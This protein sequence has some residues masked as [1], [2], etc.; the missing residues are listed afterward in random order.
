MEGATWLPLTVLVLLIVAVETVSLLSDAGHRLRRAISS[1]GGA[2]VIRALAVMEQ[3]GLRVLPTGFAGEGPDGARRRLLVYNLIFWALVTT[4]GAA[5]LLLNWPWWLAAV[6]VAGMLVLQT[7]DFRDALSLKNHEETGSQSRVSRRRLL[8]GLVRLLIAGGVLA[9]G[10]GV[11]PRMP[12]GEL[13]LRSGVAIGGIAILYAAVLIRRAAARYG[14]VVD[15]MARFGED[16]S[17]SDV[18]MLRSFQDDL[19]SMRGVDPLL[20]RLGLLV[21][22]RVRFEECIASVVAGQRRLIAIGQP[23][24]ALPALGAVRTYVT[25]DEWQE[26]I[27]QTVRR[28]GAIVMIA[29]GTGGFEWELNLLRRTGHLAKAV[30]FIPPIGVE[31]RISRMQDLFVRLGLHT[32]DGFDPD[33]F[34]EWGF[35][36]VFMLMA[37]GFDEQGEPVFYMSSGSDWAG[38]VS[39]VVLSLDF[40]SGKQTPPEFGAIA[41]MAGLDLTSGE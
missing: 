4:V 32:L 30:I 40:L 15:G 10:W 17:R 20:G 25:D 39:T 6:I 5:S 37:I 7:V 33:E 19:M 3:R 28:V 36:F 31:E 21:G 34:D 14:A 26:V 13:W 24:E 41:R 27:D 8:V 23:G 11:D 35:S 16:A 1:G 22:Y 38:Y 12:A 9:I 2:E 29:A 18:L